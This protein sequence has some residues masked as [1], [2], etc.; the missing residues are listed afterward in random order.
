MISK[1]GKILGVYANRRL[2][3]ESRMKLLRQM[4]LDNCLGFQRIS[5]RSSGLLQ[6]WN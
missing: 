4:S 3:T 2:Q 1:A 6:K 5:S